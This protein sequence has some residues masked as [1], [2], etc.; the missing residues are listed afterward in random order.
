MYGSGPVIHRLLWSHRAGGAPPSRAFG[1]WTTLNTTI[2][3]LATAALLLTGCSSSTPPAAPATAAPTPT[4]TAS[5]TA[6]APESIPTA[7]G[8]ADKTADFKAA[9]ANAA[10]VGQVKSATQTEPGR[11][12]I[13]TS[14]V[15]PRGADGSE[16]AK[17]AIAICES[18]VALFGPSY[19]A[20]MEDDGTHFV[21]FGHPSVPKGA[22][23][24]V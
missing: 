19:V 6:A 1:H 22:C 12:S 8:E 4:T 5:Q 9:N 15:D 2:P 11:I 20:V 3:A 10:W 16:A 13:D 23:A 14:V 21:L 24:E 18:A 7:S 17:T